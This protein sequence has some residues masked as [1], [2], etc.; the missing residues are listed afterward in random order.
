MDDFLKHINKS[1]LES[2]YSFCQQQMIFTKAVP[3][4]LCIAGKRIFNLFYVSAPNNVLTIKK[5]KRE[6]TEDRYKNVYIFF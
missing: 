3:R 5:H 6:N 2:M 1:E 4:N